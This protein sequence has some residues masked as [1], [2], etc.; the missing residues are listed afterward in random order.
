MIKLGHI[1]LLLIKQLAFFFIC[2]IIVHLKFTEKNN[3]F[4]GPYRHGNQA[5]SV[6]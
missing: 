2:G 3:E 1:R 5:Y 6:C 4:N